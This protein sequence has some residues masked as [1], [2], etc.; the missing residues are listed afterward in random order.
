MVGVPTRI[1]RLRAL[2]P[3]GAG[4]AVGAGVATALLLAAGPRGGVAEAVAAP[5]AAVPTTTAPAATAGRPGLPPEAPSAGPMVLALQDALKLRAP[6]GTANVQVLAHGQNAWMGRL[7]MAPGAK[8]PEHADATEEYLFV[9]AG[10]GT[11]WIDGKASKTRPG[12]TV[13][14]PSGARVRYENGGEGMLAIQVFAGP[15]P[16]AKYAGWKPWTP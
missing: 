15:A 9:L 10:Q 5:T 14:M 7:D 8:V 11:V 6:T 4:V 3:F 13:Y 1:G 2:L 12:S 16:A